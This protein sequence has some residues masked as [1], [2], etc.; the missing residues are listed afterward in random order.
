MYCFRANTWYRTKNP[1]A[2]RVFVSPLLIASSTNNR[3]DS[4]ATYAYSFHIF[5][6]EFFIVFRLK[7]KQQKIP[8]ANGKAIR[9]YVANEST[10]HLK[11]FLYPPSTLV[12]SFI[13]E[14][15]AKGTFLV[16]IYTCAAFNLKLSVTTQAKPSVLVV[17][18]GC[19]CVLVVRS[20]HFEPPVLV[21]ISSDQSILVVSFWSTRVQ[22]KVLFCALSL[23]FL[24]QIHVCTLVKWFLE[25][26]L[27]QITLAS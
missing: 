7:I 6:L 19:P 14:K 15:S 23:Y 24:Y 12:V 1:R 21:V 10:R 17:F 13:D 5:P 9:A 2:V 11:P 22:H 18:S 20:G 8:S 27:F 25:T 26:N 16:L 4:F 3:V